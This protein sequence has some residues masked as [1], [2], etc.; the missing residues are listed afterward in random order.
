MRDGGS[1]DD[2]T[3]VLARLLADA[4]AAGD[5]ILDAGSADAPRPE[6][7]PDGRPTGP[8]D[9]Q[10][11][12]RAPMPWSPPVALGPLPA[13]LR[14]EAERVIRAQ[15]AAVEYLEG[16]R[17]QASRHLAAVMVVPAGHRSGASVYLDTLG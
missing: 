1:G 8:S 10:P 12:A 2:W 7:Q 16:R 17:D 11:A 15:A 4:D 5:G 13:A 3:S 6:R 14:G 9:G